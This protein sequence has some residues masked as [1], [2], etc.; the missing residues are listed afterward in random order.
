M[1]ESEG[2]VIDLMRAA[3]SAE[4]GLRLVEAFLGDGF[5]LPFLGLAFVGVAFFG[6]PS[7]FLGVF[8]GLPFAAF[9]LPGVAS[10]A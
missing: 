10:F 3:S 2:R 8:F 1:Q 7:S 9:A 5:G 4:S 6:V